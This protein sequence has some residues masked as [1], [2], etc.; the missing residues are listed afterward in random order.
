MQRIS[1]KILAFVFLLISLTAYVMG[2]ESFLLP[3]TVWVFLLICINLAVWQKLMRLATFTMLVIWSYALLGNL[4]PQSTSGPSVDVGDIERTP[5][6]FIAAGE[7]LFNGK[8]KCSTCHVIGQ[9]A[10]KPRCPDLENIGIAAE[11]RKPGMSAKDYFVESL[12]MPSTYLVQG[13]G[14]IMP[15]IWKPPIALTPLEIETVIAFLQSQGGEPDLT[16]IKPPVDVT[17]F[18]ETPQRELK[19]DPEMGQYVFIEHLECIKC[20]KVGDEGG[21]GGVGPDLTEIGALNT[22]DY[23]EESILDPNANIVSGYGWTM[24][25]LESGEK[26]SGTII[27]EDE[28]K[29]TL[30]LDEGMGLRA[31]QE[32]IVAKKD[33]KIRKIRRTKDILGQGYFWIQAVVKENKNVSGV[34]TEEDE[35]TLTLK[36]SDDLVKITKSD[37]TR[38]EGRKMMVT[39]KMPMYDEVITIRQFED[40]LTY[41]ASL[42]GE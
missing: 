22:V 37:I 35:T 42:K 13:Y 2:A 4:I 5:D 36:A 29:L 38:I 8:G 30:L 14:K 34:I 9:G 18:E 25:R 31:G 27:Q 23:I 28:V 16:P 32:Q 33:L 20:H 1:L 26:F 10:T 11:S 15:E 3:W 21:Q 39:S 19:G 41:L 40:L 17:A 24:L 6:A 7:A 12:Y